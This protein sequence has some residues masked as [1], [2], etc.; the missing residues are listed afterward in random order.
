MSEQTEVIFRVP[1]E[2]FDLIGVLVAL[3]WLEEQIRARRWVN[4]IPNEY[5]GLEAAYRI[6]HRVHT[7][8]GEAIGRT[9]W[10]RPDLL[11][12]Q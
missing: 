10:Q 11:A 2:D 7:R 6:M 5:T 9:E 8:Y 4:T 1:D 3:V 12:D